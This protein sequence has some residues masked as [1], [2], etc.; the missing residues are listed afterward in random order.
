MKTLLESRDDKAKLAVALYCYRAQREL[1]SLAAALGGIDA[2]VFT[3]GVGENAAPIR[4]KICEGAAWLGLDFDAD[5]NGKG[6]PRISTA[7]SR[8]ASW[9][10]F[11]DEELTIA[12]HTRRLLSA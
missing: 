1:G 11:T 4:A 7:G 6:G 8:V 2:L 12:R 10:V 9:I 3:G 5:A